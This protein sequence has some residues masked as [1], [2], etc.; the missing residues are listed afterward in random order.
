[1][2]FI[3]GKED[4]TYNYYSGSEFKLCKEAV[5]TEQFGEFTLYIIINIMK[6]TSISLQIVL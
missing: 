5:S 6:L 2:V 1:M 4:F 3:Y